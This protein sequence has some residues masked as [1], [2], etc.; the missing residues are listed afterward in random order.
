MTEIYEI[1]PLRL[2]AEACVLARDGA[3]LPLGKRAVAVLTVLV[4]AAPQ[5]VTKTRILE[6]AWPGVIVDESNLAV[7]ILS[8][9]RALATVSAAEHWLETLARR[10]YRFVGPVTRVPQDT[11]G[12]SANARPR[13]N[14]PHPVTSFVGRERELAELSTLL[15]GTRLLTLTGA[16]GVGKT[17]LAMRLATALLTGYRDGACLVEFADLR[18]PDLVPQTA[19]N[20]LGLQEQPGRTL[21][22]TLI[23]HLR[24]RQLLLLL[25]NAEHLL[26]AC[27]QLVDALLRQCP[28]VTLV[29][30]SR[31][32]LGVPG[33]M[34]YRVP[35]LSVPDVTD[36]A[37]PQGLM[38]YESVRLFAERVRLHRPHF[39]LTD[40]NTRAIANICR[41][42]EGIALAIE[43]AAARV[44]SMSV[45]DVDRRLDQRFALLT[46]G[47]R[48]LPA[49]QQTLRA[50]IDW[51]FDLLDDTE[52]TLFCA[53]SVFAGG[54]TLEA[55]E[56]VCAGEAIPAHDVLDL[57]TSLT[58]K[59]LVVVEDRDAG[60]RYRLLETVR[61]YATERARGL[62]GRAPW[63]AR[64]LAYFFALAEEAESK[65]KGIDQQAW[66]DRLETE[67]DNFRAA[68]ARSTAVH[69][70][71]TTG[72]LLASAFARFWLVRGYLTEG[73]GWFSRL[74]A[75]APGAD[76]ATRSKAL[77][78]AGI[79]AWK[80]GD[81][82]AAQE[83]Y[84]QSLTLRQELGDRK[85]IGAVLNN[86]GLLAY[87]QGD[88]R[89]ARLLHQES[90]VIDR[91]LGDRWGVGVSLIHLASLA[92]MQGDYAA[93]RALNQESLAIFREFGDRGH[94]ANALRSLGNLR[95][96]E[97][98]HEAARA[99]YDESLTMCR[100]LG[101]RSGIA[102]ALQ[103]LGVAAHQSGDD[104]AARELLEDSLAIYRELG[105]REGTAKT[106]ANLGHVAATRGDHASALTLQQ[107]SLAIYRQLSDRWG[108]AF[109]IEGLAGAKAAL[110]ESRQAAA[111]WGAVERLREEI[112]APIAPSERFHHDHAVSGARA[113]IGDADTFDR[114]WRE[115]RDMTL[116]Q[117][118][119]FG[120]SN[121]TCN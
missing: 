110:G 98:E 59:S 22:Q 106:L 69:G 35:S 60:T 7:Q 112:A 74:L 15:G 111:L 121:G 36:E 58:D 102:G 14:L 38:D 62:F 43:L 93:A 27:A 92:M 99:L 89:T 41:R 5:H 96:Q 26:P 21:I 24:A 100:E 57:L 51:S 2:D 88:Y 48:T 104:S 44:R 94:V 40:Q 53:I 118:I 113:A 32:R 67:H 120:L 119:A 72:L 34:T 103:G 23:D 28:L 115:G 50:A 63:S 6:A 39:T 95:S 45:S 91:E 31:E 68:L 10:G 108:I 80:Q 70:D 25:D 52:K 19:I 8:I 4:R 105:D 76:S 83:F 75:A 71:G 16:G 73:R 79:F 13:S 107:E 42:L 29:V 82:R 49:R 61:E 56:R 3:P 90:L 86:Q 109:S 81:Y 20:A 33:E 78:W 64:H 55:A 18:D 54:F 114:A 9:R 47:S 116:E 66:L 85:G 84:E 65:L 37:T 12:G 17:R 30:T 97:G 101:D 117:A 77:N 1:G 87:E 11:I 46:G